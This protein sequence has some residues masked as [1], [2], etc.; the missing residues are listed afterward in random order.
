MSASVADST[1]LNCREMV[2]PIS[3]LITP[4]IMANQTKEFICL[5][6]KNEQ[7]AGAA[8]R[9]MIRIAPTMSKAITMQIETKVIKM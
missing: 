8:R 4:K 5:L 6:T 3:V 9:E 2:I 1:K 7:A